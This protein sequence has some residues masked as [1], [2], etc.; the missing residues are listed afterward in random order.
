MEA[1]AARLILAGVEPGPERQQGTLNSGA[2]PLVRKSAQQ[3]AWASPAPAPGPCPC[4]AVRQAALGPSGTKRPKK[5]LGG[6]PKK[7]SKHPASACCS[8]L[9]TQV[10][11]SECTN[12]RPAYQLPSW[13]GSHSGARGRQGAITA[14]H[15][16]P[17]PARAVRSGCQGLPGPA[18]AGPAV[19]G[20]Q[21]A[22]AQVPGP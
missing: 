20:D 7:K 14:L 9:P 2:A 18:V 19:H 8:T 21:L 10:Q 6:P 16:A 11:A 17:G 1:A 5:A 22:M 15:A 4:R 13:P 12:Q 3:W